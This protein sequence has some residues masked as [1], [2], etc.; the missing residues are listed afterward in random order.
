M[1]MSLE[2][3][4]A[5]ISP[6]TTPTGYRRR[7]TSFSSSSSGSLDSFDRFHQGIPG[8]T[9]K[10]FK[11]SHRRSPEAML[12]RKLKKS[13]NMPFHK[14][15]FVPV[16]VRKLYSCRALRKEWYCKCSKTETFR[17][18]KRRTLNP[19]YLTVH[20]VNHP[21]PGIVA[22]ALRRIYS[23]EPEVLPIPHSVRKM[24]NT[25][26]RPKGPNEV[27]PEGRKRLRMI[28]GK[29]TAQEQSYANSDTSLKNTLVH[30]GVQE[31]NVT[32]VGHIGSALAGRKVTW[33]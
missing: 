24:P 9:T 3:Y 25:N 8:Y 2:A 29:I 27:S 18:F 5:G 31:K 6:A 13:R 1:A 15:G 21:I 17:S 19:T 4:M 16:V 28:F 33:M 22:D 14:A 30:F 23:R 26:V 12:K 7:V 10:P 20:S 11:G 32:I